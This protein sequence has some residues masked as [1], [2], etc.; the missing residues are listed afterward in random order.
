MSKTQRTVAFWT[1]IARMAETQQVTRFGHS[2]KA[3]R[4]SFWGKRQRGEEKAELARP[5]KEKEKERSRAEADA[6]EKTER[7]KED[8]KNGSGHNEE[9]KG[10]FQRVEQRPPIGRSGSGKGDPFD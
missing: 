10:G 9:D 8:A 6:A 3:D 5:R 7:L 4:L 2:E 1:I